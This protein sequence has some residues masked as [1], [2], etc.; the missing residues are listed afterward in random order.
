VTWRWW[1]GPAAAA[2][3]RELLTVSAAADLAA[4]GVPTPMCQVLAEQ[5]AAA[6]LAGHAAAHPDA[7]ERLIAD[8]D[9]AGIV[10]RVLV[11]P[12]MPWVLVDLVVRP[13]RRGR[14]AGT[15]ALE[16][17]LEQADAAGRAVVLRVRRGNPA[18]RL[19]RRSGFT[20]VDG[21]ELDVRMRREA[22]RP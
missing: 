3:A 5:Q 19:Y 8:P 1:D 7:E 21:D 18:Q 20:V 14:G 12:G 16:R 17:V 10:G 6:R 9:G 2:A 15:W 11:D 13:D 22:P 4:A